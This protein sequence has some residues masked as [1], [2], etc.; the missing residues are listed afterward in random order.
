[1][2][3]PTDKLALD[4]KNYTLPH[5]CVSSIR[6]GLDIGFAKLDRTTIGER[7]DFSHTVDDCNRIGNVREIVNNSFVELRR[8]TVGEFADVSLS[9]DKNPSLAQIFKATGR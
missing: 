8:A 4:T 3:R 2:L 6:K 9:F 5:N 1:M 7:T